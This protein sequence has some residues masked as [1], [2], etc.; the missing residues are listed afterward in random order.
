MRFLSVSLSHGN[1]ILASILKVGHLI[2]IKI[3]VCYYNSRLVRI[4]HILVF[5]R[6]NLTIYLISCS[7]SLVLSAA[8]AGGILSHFLFLLCK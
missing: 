1:L 2:D 8:C 6:S 5:F 4:L 7:H 3:S